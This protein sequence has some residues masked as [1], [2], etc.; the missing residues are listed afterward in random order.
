MSSRRVVRAAAGRYDAQ[1]DDLTDEQIEELHD[2]LLKLRDQLTHQLTAAREGSKPVD[3]DEPI[4]RL[5][6]MDAMQQQ[7]MTQAHRRRMEV[8]L[9]QVKAALSRHE[10][11]EYGHCVFCDDVIGFGRLSVR[12]ESPM[13]LA[14]QSERETR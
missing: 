1:M 10:R 6:R 13:C 5:S 3:L 11:D 12:P 8:R 7:Q 9:Q 14:C 2:K 4:G